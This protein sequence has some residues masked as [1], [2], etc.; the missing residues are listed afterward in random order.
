MQ[1]R[2]N[3][4]KFW[5]SLPIPEVSRHLAI[6]IIG[7]R[8]QFPVQHEAHF[9]PA[10]W[11]VPRVGYLGTALCTGLQSCTESRQS[12][13]GLRSAP[14]ISTHHRSL[15]LHQHY[16]DSPGSAQPSL[17]Y[18]ISLGT[19]LQL[20]AVGPLQSPAWE[21]T[22]FGIYNRNPNTCSFPKQSKTVSQF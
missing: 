10:E 15:V 16:T 9:H 19:E 5:L 7:N 22:I 6:G 20:R 11:A 8:T 17:S 4:S 2:H 1:M 14:P 12:L 21:N 13:W 3:S 18:L